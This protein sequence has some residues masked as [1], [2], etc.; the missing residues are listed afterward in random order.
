MNYTKGKRF[1]LVLAIILFVTGFLATS[2]VE[3]AR[4]WDYVE[5]DKNGNAKTLTVTAQY[6]EEDTTTLTE[7]AWI[8]FDTVDTFNRLRVSGDVKL[9]LKDGAVLRARNG[10]ELNNGNT[11]TIY[12]QKEGTGQLI[13]GR[14]ASTGL[15]MAENCAGIG[16]GAEGH[17]DSGKLSIHGGHIEAYGG[18]G[19]AG[20][21][22][23]YGGN[24]GEFHLYNGTVIA[25]GNRDA[26]FYGGAGIGSGAKAGSYDWQTNVNIYGGEVSAHGSYKAAGIGGGSGA[27]SQTI[28]IKGGTVE[29]FGGKDGPGVGSGQA[30]NGPASFIMEGGSL[31]AV[32]QDGGVGIG[33]GYLSNGFSAS[34]IKGGHII[35]VAGGKAERAFG[36]GQEDTFSTNNWDG[37]MTFE[38]YM[39]V[40]AGTSNYD[41]ALVT[42]QKND[43]KKAACQNK[44]YVEIYP[45]E[46]PDVKYTNIDADQHKWKCDICGTEQNEKHIWDDHGDCVCG[47]HA[48][49]LTV[50]FLREDGSV[51]SEKQVPYGDLL[52]DHYPDE[53]LTKETDEDGIKYAFSKWDYNGAT[54]PE[55][56][57]ES[58]DLTPVF[59]K[60]CLVEFRR[61]DGSLISSEYYPSGTHSDTI[62]WPKRPP[63]DP[64]KYEY[65]EFDSWS[66]DYSDTTIHRKTIITAKY[67]AFPKEHVFSNFTVEWAEDYSTVTVKAMC[68]LH[69]NAVEE[70]ET[71]PTKTRPVWA[72]PGDRCTEMGDLEYYFEK[73]DFPEDSVF[74]T[75]LPDELLTTKTVEKVVDPIGHDWSDPWYTQANHTE[76]IDGG[77]Y[78]VPESYTGNAYCKNDSSHKL[79]EKTDAVKIIDVEPTCEAIGYCHYEFYFEN[80]VFSREPSKQ[81]KVNRL[82]HDWGEPTYKWS[83][84][85]KT[86]TATRVC[87]R[88]SSHIQTETVDATETIIKAPTCEE[89]GQT[90]FTSAD[91]ENTAFEKQEV[92]IDTEALGH[93]WKYDS[94][95]WS[96]DYSTVT[97]KAVCA[98][99]DS[100]VLEETALV[101]EEISEQPDCT[102]TGLRILTAEF[103]H[104]VF[105]PQT[106]KQEVPALGHDFG[107]WEEKSDET[108]HY[109]IR[110]CAR[111]DETQRLEIA[112]EDCEHN[113]LTT[114]QRVDP[115]CTTDGYEEYYQCNFCHQYVVKE[116]DEKI[117]LTEENIDDYIQKLT[118]PALGHDYGEWVVEAEPACT[119]NG[120][121]RRVC[122]RDSSHEEIRE[123]AALG[124]TPAAAV[125][126]NETSPTCLTE[127]SYDE[128]IYCSTC[129]EK[130]SEE[131]VVVEPIGHNWGEITY[132]WAD[133]NSTVTATR[134]CN[135]DSSHVETETVDTTSEITKQP[136]CAEKG[137]TTY[138]SAAFENTA[139]EVQTKTEEMAID[140]NA[141]SWGDISYAWADDNSTL[142]ATR[143]C[144]ND[145]SH[146]ETETVGT[147]S[148]TT[149]QPTCTEK[150]ETTYTSVAFNNEAFSVQIKTVANIEALDHDWGEWT[151]TQAPT[152]S[153]V[154]KEERVCNRNADHKETR[155]V[156][157]DPKA[158]KWG[159]WTESIPATE[160][161]E[162]EE[163]RVCEHN[164]E[165][166]ETRPIAKLDHV[167]RLSH[168]DVKPAT[169]T[170]AGNIEYWVCTEGE[171]PCG[172][173]FADAEGTEELN[174]EELVIAALNHAWGEVT[175]KWADDN[176]EATATRVCEHDATHVETET[177]DVTSEITKQPTCSAAGETTYTAIFENPAFAEQSKTIEDVAIDP[178][179]H[180]WGAVAYEWADDNSKVTATRTCAH[181]ATHTET[182]TV[183]TKSSVTKE[184]TEIEEGERTY[185]ATFTNPAFAKQTKTESIPKKDPV[186][187]DPA[188][189]DPTDPEPQ[190]APSG[191]VSYRNT[192]GN[193]T[194]WTK[195]SAATADFTFK[196]SENDS[197]TFSHFIGIQVDGKDVAASSYTA[198]AGSVIVKLKPSYLETLSV[199]EHTLTA[200]FDDGNKASAKFT[201]VAKKASG[202]ST[203]TN[204][205]TKK[206]N[207]VNTSTTAP[208]TGDNSNMLLWITLLCA[209]MLVL[210]NVI[211]ARRRNTMGRG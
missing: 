135:T 3:A 143:V 17:R 128:V 146:V 133:D 11:L 164:A 208:K 155:D 43:D 18:Y 8:V 85:H 141:H 183:E 80:E 193:G 59:T 9:I 5:Y 176:S 138:T 54:P 159:E 35:A 72:N 13:A 102:K 61:D 169:C 149:K 21:G 57:T 90:R 205:T 14:M 60:Y 47:A 150:G 105:K 16:G 39:L 136:T 4:D 198:E 187:P 162:G 161:T 49:A 188:K 64:T 117:T 93:L 110:Q 156:D 112:D 154:G 52:A 108:G 88:D 19:A 116:G 24:G 130:L 32:G 144:K 153:A 81:Y 56:V 62:E 38:Q 177:A 151:Q 175:Y 137:E 168:V 174:A 20:I 170:E 69:D 63:K 204:S 114:I 199:G 207:V 182:E 200:L 28:F 91:F 98:R 66:M 166:K 103:E 113:D 194:Q 22:G 29:A 75:D 26:S 87:K 7:G 190:P 140:S 123:T 78:L 129:G 96:E 127:G 172:R 33:G 77:M 157:V 106:L 46:H 107:E 41:A 34:A 158:H 31:Y 58:M 115:T 73:T 42:S 181:D 65:Y 121:E 55:K 2:R 179:A 186:K 97:V 76:Y 189:P 132:T 89:K 68:E 95:R 206:A 191:S 10:I 196:R 92:T 70:E 101:K 30:N 120:L 184:P 122:S 126:E 163:T 1:V 83:D 203:T 53:T 180:A 12:G 15:V 209:S 131:H 178:D 124:H 202:N 23:G 50:R 160:T 45:C 145:S 6:V 192:E 84:D 51:L 79:V 139:F 195:G 134:V 197:E 71:I 40:K 111:C 119:K 44:K 48:A 171:N 142:T 104:E 74:Y 82:G 210:F 109:R 173:Y 86:V 27:G 148:E 25:Y 211:N 185:T 94:C 201:V 67:K 36:H 152:C 99:D 118:I 147:T 125:R 165:H 100:H 167:H 37:S